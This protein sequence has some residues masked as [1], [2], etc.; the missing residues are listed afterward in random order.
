MP[1]GRIYKVERDLEEKIE[2]NLN[3]SKDK[4]NI[5]EKLKPLKMEVDTT[6]KKKYEKID[7]TTQSP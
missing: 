4:K 1:A 2:I 7:L 6:N 3:I 5:I